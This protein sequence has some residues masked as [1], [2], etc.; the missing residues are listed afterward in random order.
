M[1][2]MRTLAAGAGAENVE[3]AIRLTDALITEAR[4]IANERGAERL[5]KHIDQ[6]AGIQ[7]DA[8]RSLQAGRNGQALKQT[9]RAR[10]LLKNA[11]GSARPPLHRDDVRKTLVQTDSA[12]DRLRN[13]L[14]ESG[15]ETARDIYA[16]ALSQQE[17]AWEEFR[18]SELRAALAHT[19]L[20]NMVATI[21]PHPSTG[22]I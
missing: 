2:A 21:Q 15:D 4:D 22:L 3:Q 20:A 10:E 6:A 9:L 17:K 12:L 11:L 18:R 1:R 8:R 14:D 16:R 5:L 13:A 7:A 19:R